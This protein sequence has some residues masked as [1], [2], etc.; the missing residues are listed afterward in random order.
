MRGS[1]ASTKLFNI[2]DFSGLILESYIQKSLEALRVEC[3]TYHL[4]C[5][6]GSSAFL[7]QV[8]QENSRKAWMKKLTGKFRCV[9]IR[10]VAVARRN[11]LLDGPRI[12]TV[13]KKNLVVVCFENEEIRILEA[14]TNL[15]CGAS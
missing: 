8:C 9:M 6:T 1:G 4:S 5:Q 3:V 2:E 11:P 13:A 14:E 12:R 7:R 10:K 15:G